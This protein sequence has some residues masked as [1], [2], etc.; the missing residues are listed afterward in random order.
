MNLSAWVDV[1]IGVTVVYLGASL[2]VTVIN[3]YISQVLNSRGNELVKSLQTLIGD[4]NIRQTLAQSPALRPFFE[5]ESGDAPSYVDSQVL[6][7]MLVG[8]LASGA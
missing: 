2:F 3:E 8:G 6:A 7:R 5:P 4:T 1:A